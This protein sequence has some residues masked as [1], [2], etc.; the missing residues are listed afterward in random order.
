MRRVIA[1]LIAL[2]ALTAWPLAQAT[3]D[4]LVA[5]IEGPQTGRDGDLVPLSIQAAMQKAGVPGLSIAVIRDFEIHWSRGY[6]VA[7]VV[8]GATTVAELVIVEPA[9]AVTRTTRVRVPLKPT[10][11]VPRFQRTVRLVPEYV[12]PFEAE[13]NSRPVG[14]TS[15]STASVDA[16]GPPLV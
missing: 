6:G 8:S 12:P 13:T 15:L 14:S 1:G 9:G 4:P 16:F 11:T 5:A 10:L 7:D 3:P 2:V